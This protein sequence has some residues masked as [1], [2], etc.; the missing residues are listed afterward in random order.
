M[1]STNTMI[2]LFSLLYIILA[3]T[4]VVVAPFSVCPINTVLVGLIAAI[5]GFA[6]VSHES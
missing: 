4:T 2:Q 1:D 5:L 3:I 6:M